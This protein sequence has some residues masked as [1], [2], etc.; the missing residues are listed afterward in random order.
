MTD[1]SPALDA[2]LANDRVTIFGAVTLTVGSDIVRL[3]DGSAHM[4]LGGDLYTG[5]DLTYGTLSAME[6]FED[7]SGDEAPGIAITLNP[8]SD[9]AALALSGPDVQGEAIQIHIGARND[10]TGA[11]IGEPFLLFD[12]EVDVTK[13]EF[14]KNMLQVSLE[15]VGGMERLFFDDEGM[16]LAPSFHQQVWPGET[17]MNHVTGIRDTIYWGSNAPTRQTGYSIF[18]R[19]V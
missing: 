19:R 10:A 9:A 6:S 5:E 7:G 13:H 16:R 17:G 3:L 12:G 2:E 15:C 11:V 8:A 4:L 18:G 1:L 14:G